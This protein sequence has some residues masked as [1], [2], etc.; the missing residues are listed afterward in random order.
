MM[1]ETGVDAFHRGAFEIVQPL[2]SG[3]RAGSDALILAAALEENAGGRLA[4]LGAGAGVA[5]IAALAMNEN[6]EAVLVELDPVMAVCARQSLALPANARL[7]TRAIVVEADIC[8]TG[9]RREAAGLA[10]AAFDHVIA[11][12]PY[13]LPSERPSPDS[14]RRL[15]HVMDEGE[16]DAWMRT[17][18]AIL[19]PGGR[20]F[21][22]W[23]P[24]QM[25]DLLEGAKGRF[26]GIQI[27]PLHARKDSPA[28]RMIVRAVRG[29]RAPLAIFP[30]IV[31]H[32][33]DG[34]PTQIA[35]ALLNGKARLNWA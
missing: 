20:F 28:G 19:K 10:N 25:A 27:I 32:E 9:R 15:A 3:H 26:G 22:V 4:D 34:K 1:V 17:A 7:S 35:Q 18:A 13:Y 16:L 30:G 33:D 11:N 14:R 24:Q 12:P 29:S 5:A 21:L 2:K 6:L 8:L 31:L 23:R